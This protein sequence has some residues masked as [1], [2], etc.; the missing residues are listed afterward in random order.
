MLFDRNNSL[1]I[2]MNKLAMDQQYD[3]LIEVFIKRLASYKKQQQI[4]DQTGQSNLSSTKFNKQEI[5]NNHIYL[6]LEALYF[7]VRNN[8]Y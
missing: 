8:A 2:L 5:P 4:N 3:K 7:I 6:L 1:L